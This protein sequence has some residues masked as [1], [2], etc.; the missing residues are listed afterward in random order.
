MYCLVLNPVLVIRISSSS[1]YRISRGNVRGHA[2]VHDRIFSRNV[3]AQASFHACTCSRNVRACDYASICARAS[4]IILART[5]LCLFFHARDSTR[6]CACSPAIICACG[7]FSTCLSV[8]PSNT[9][10]WGDLGHGS[11][12][13]HVYICG[14]LEDFLCHVQ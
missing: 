6:I 1:C 11:R 5:S 8:I 10:L 7:G 9:L 3:W 2:S 13:D 14:A 12:T 4:V